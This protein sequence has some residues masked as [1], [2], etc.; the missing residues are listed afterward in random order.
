MAQKC[1]WVLTKA[2]ISVSI[3]QYLTAD[4]PLALILCFPMQW[5]SD[6]FIN[7]CIPQVLLVIIKPLKVKSLCSTR[8]LILY[9]LKKSFGTSIWLV[10]D[11]Y[12]APFSLLHK[13]MGELGPEPAG[14]SLAEESR[15]EENR[16]CWLWAPPTAEAHW[17][18]YQT[19]KSLFT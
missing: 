7:N 14:L 9:N 19:S 11:R 3:Y 2:L 5:Y 13:P 8:M 4:L 1:Q 10:L 16:K 15:Q 18:V 17:S 12:D 6:L